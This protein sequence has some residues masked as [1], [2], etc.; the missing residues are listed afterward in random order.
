MKTFGEWVLCIPIEHLLWTGI[1]INKQI[2]Y[3]TC[4]KLSKRNVNKQT[5]SPYDDPNETKI[6]K[7]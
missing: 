3:I 4:S 1:P 7:T 2:S 5:N 6:T